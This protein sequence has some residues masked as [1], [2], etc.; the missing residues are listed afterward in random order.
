MVCVE[1]TKTVLSTLVEEIDVRIHREIA[2][3]I[4]YIHDVNVV[5]NVDNVVII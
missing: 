1:K 2:D 3:D 4:V 5:S